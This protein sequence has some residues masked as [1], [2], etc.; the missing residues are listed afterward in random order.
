MI[1]QVTIRLIV[2]IFL[3]SIWNYFAGTKSL[4]KNSYK[5]YLKFLNDCTKSND[6]KDTA[7]KIMILQKKLNDG[8]TVEEC[9]NI[10]IDLDS[11]VDEYKHVGLLAS[12]FAILITLI[13]FVIKDVFFV[14]IKPYYDME[15]IIFFA[16]TFSTFTLFYLGHVI[17]SYYRRYRKLIFFQRL[18]E[19]SLS[20]K[21]KEIS[22]RK[23][24][25]EAKLK[26]R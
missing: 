1:L 16:L 9:R 13:L 5:Q 7:N 2:V 12:F 10:K 14:I 24:L 23:T 8:F 18:I 3:L 21:E 6:M 25:R 11:W 15:E 20:L 17:I 19:N 22:E 4:L 26:R